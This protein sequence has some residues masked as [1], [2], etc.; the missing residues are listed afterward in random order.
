[1][2]RLAL[3]MISICVILG[4]A[5]AQRLPQN[6][7]PQSYDLTFTPDLTSATICRSSRICRPTGTAR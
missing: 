7:T 6:V 5:G 2:S 3:L 4:S 1:M